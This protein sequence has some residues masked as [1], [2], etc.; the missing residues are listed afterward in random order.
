LYVFLFLLLVPL[1]VWLT[2]S[3]VSAFVSVLT[4]SCTA[5]FLSYARRGAELRENGIVFPSKGPPFVAWSRIEQCRWL[6]DGSAFQ[7]RLAFGPEEI[8]VAP[9]DMPEVSGILLKRVLLISSDGFAMN[10]GFTR[11]KEALLESFRREYRFFQ[12]DLRTI[13]LLTVVAASAFSWIGLRLETRRREEAALADLARFSP[14]F[15]GTAG[16]T[17]YLAFSPVVSAGLTAD[18]LALLKEFHHLR[19]LG[20][21]GTGITDDGLAEIG[22]LR[23][24][25]MLYLNNSQITDAGLVQLEGLTNLEFISLENTRVTDEGVRRLQNALPEVRIQR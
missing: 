22:S 19:A 14:A 23:G 5:V 21:S 16:H 8:G 20:L 17:D 2:E 12:F 1:A 15:H 9:G 6:P 10:R 11:S 13:L 7:A 4:I 25:R 18:D 3:D 24:L